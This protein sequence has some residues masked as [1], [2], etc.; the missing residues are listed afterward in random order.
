MRCHHLHFRDLQS[1]NSR[2]ELVFIL[3]GLHRLRALFCRR[4]TANKRGNVL[5]CISCPLRVHGIQS[6]RKCRSWAVN[7]RHSVGRAHNSNARSAKPRPVLHLG[8]PADHLTDHEA[9]GDPD[10]N[11]HGL[12]SLRKTS[13]GRIHLIDPSKNTTH[14]MR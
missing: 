12:K 7:G 2:K 5:G 4:S 13:T 3:C 10:D 11:E 6:H 8:V 9:A 1:T 14:V